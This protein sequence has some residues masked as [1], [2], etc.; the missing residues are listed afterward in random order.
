MK[1]CGVCGRTS[2]SSFVFCPWCGNRF[3]TGEKPAGKY[4][5]PWKD[6]P[7]A[8]N[9]AR[10]KKYKDTGAFWFG[11]L[12]FLLPPLG[13]IL[14]LCW[15]DKR[16]RRASAVSAGAFTTIVL[17]A[18]AAAVLLLAVFGGFVTLDQ[19]SPGNHETAQ[20]AIK[21]YNNIP[22]YMAL[23]WLFPMHSL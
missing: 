16:P 5:Q 17:L 4:T 8:N 6:V 15:S 19:F 9:S 22:L 18:V 20:N 3:Q 1:N 23:L 21:M 10:V 7:A 12:G 14:Y 2:E 11:L 13:L